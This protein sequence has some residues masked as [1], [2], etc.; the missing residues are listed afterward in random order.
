VRALSGLPLADRL[1]NALWSY[2]AYLGRMFWPA[3]LAVYY[4]YSHHLAAAQLVPAGVLL[5]GATVLAVRCWRSRPY[6]AVGWFWYLGTL[7]PVIGLIQVGGQASADRYTY[8]PTIGLTIAMAWGGMELLER[9]PEAWKPI[10]GA[11]L[12]AVCACLVLAVIQVSYWANSGLLFQH[13]AEVTTGNYV[14]DNNLADYYLTQMRTEEARAPV[15]EALRFNPDYPE[16]HVNLATILRRTGQMA[17]S[18]RE[19]Q[20]AIRIQPISAAAHEGYGALLLQE[21]RTVDAA[22]EFA[23]VVELQPEDADGHYNLG[24]VLAAIGRFDEGLEQL[25][26]AIRLRP[27]YAEAHHSL[28]MALISRGR[29]ND[30]LAEFVE[31]GRLLLAQGRVDEAIAV[32]TTAL[33][34]QPDSAEARRGL[35]AAKAGKRR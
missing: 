32:Y 9:Y 35:E 14:A 8:L 21:N 30:A 22:N 13:A 11:A 18:E 19:Y 15:L 1:A 24:R 2:A 17:E 23:R 7:L 31:E 33:R 27:D 6:L 28:A 4:P 12:V 5:A 26:E 16:A 10:V 3:G 29:L 25:H 34:L 20:R